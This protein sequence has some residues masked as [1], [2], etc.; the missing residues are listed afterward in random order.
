MRLSKAVLTCQLQVCNCLIVVVLA[1]RFPRGTGLYLPSNPTVNSGLPHVSTCR[2]I[3]L[4]ID[5]EGSESAQHVRMQDRLGSSKLH[6]Q[7][8]ASSCIHQHGT[9]RGM[10][11]ETATMGTSTID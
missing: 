2:L 5:P 1:V 4:R 11:L 3:V 6:E 7:C 10:V 8:K 9:L